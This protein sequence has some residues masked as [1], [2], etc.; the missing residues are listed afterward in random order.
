MLQFRLREIEEEGGVWLQETA[1]SWCSGCIVR[2]GEY[3]FDADLKVAS[4]YGCDFD[5]SGTELASCCV[6]DTGFLVAY[7]QRVD[8][9][10][11]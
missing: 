1:I 9:R 3:C 8:L 5:S 7:F 11:E 2:R 6:W 10:C 4:F